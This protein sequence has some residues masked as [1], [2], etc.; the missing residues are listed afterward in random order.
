L[1]GVTTITAASRIEKLAKIEVVESEGFR[2][3]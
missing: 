2:E 1:A 3:L